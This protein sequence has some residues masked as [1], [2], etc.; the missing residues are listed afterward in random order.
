MPVG[1]AADIT[2]T[3]TVTATSGTLTNTVVASMAASS[4]YAVYRETNTTYLFRGDSLPITG[5]GTNTGT[6]RVTG[7]WLP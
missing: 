7:R 1:T 4:G 6:Y 3:V 5:A 2:V